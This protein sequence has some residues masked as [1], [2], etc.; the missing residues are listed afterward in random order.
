MY[1]YY[2]YYYYFCNIG[3]AWNFL[4]LSSFEPADSRL[5][6]RKTRTPRARPRGSGGHQPA[7][8]RRAAA[9]QNSHCVSPTLKGAETSGSPGR[10]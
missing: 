8:D 6:A 5:A 1:Y 4:V 2:Y 7:A 3:V 9:G 10:R